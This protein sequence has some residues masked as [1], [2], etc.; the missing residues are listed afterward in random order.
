MIPEDVNAKIETAMRGIVTTEIMEGKRSI[1]VVLR[2]ADSYRENLD[3]LAQM[4]IQTPG[5]QLIPLSLVA[6]I[7]RNAT[8]PNRIDHEAGQTQITIQMNP[9]TRAA[10]DVKNDIDRVLAPHMKELTSK[11]V[12]LEMTGLFQS[13]QESS[14][15]LLLLSVVSLVCI[16]LVLYRMFGSVNM[17]LQVMSA[18]PLAMVGAVAA[19]VITG[20]DRSIPNLIGMI[21]LCG[22]ASRNGILI[23]DHYFHLVRHEGEA[24]TKEMLV[25]AGRNRAAPVLMTTLTAMLGL[26]PITFSPDTPGR[27]I[28]YPIATVI[29]GG[30]I[31]S[32][33]MDFTV[34]PALFWLFGR[35]TAEKM[36]EREKNDA[37]RMRI[38]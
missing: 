27:E 5:G 17:S 24:F 7:D 21:S 3:A 30:L 12:Y 32:T 16:L 34:R 10:V 15:T 13:E 9:Q 38:D 31:T 2:A 29:V 14:R 35:R 33:L 8:G 37:T 26:L 25:K 20:Q 18:L 6:D 4:P 28:L 36:I 23:I 1:D 22:I 11:G 19:I